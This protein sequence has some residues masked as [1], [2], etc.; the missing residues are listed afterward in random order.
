MP[1]AVAT[2]EQWTHRR[3]TSYRQ[4]AGVLTIGAAVIVL[5]HVVDVLQAG[6]PNWPALAVRLA[7]A[8]LLLAQA[9]VLRTARPATVLAGATALILGSALFTALLVATTGGATSPL[10]PF[11][12]VIMVLMPVLSFEGFAVGLAGDAILA[13]ALAVVLV[14]GGATEADLL[15]FASAATAGVIAG[16]LLARSLTQARHISEERQIALSASLERNEALVLELR[17]AM[18]NVKTLR[19]LMPICAWCRRVR[20]DTGYW[21]QI[22]AYI[23]AHSEAEVTHGLCED[24]ARTHFGEAALD[25]G[26]LFAAPVQ[27]Q[28]AGPAAP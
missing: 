17:E 10:L 25:D 16:W 12:Y 27:A 5:S 13:A 3:E 19:G 14:T 23:G 8:A 28:V 7:W 21:Q 11:T 18:A 15:S 6:G 1:K 2:T 22:E 20:S 4:T 9:H 26:D 24:C